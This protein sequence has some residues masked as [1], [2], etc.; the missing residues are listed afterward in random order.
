MSGLTAYCLGGVSEWVAFLVL[1]FSGW[2]ISIF[3]FSLFALTLSCPPDQLSFFPLDFF[4][5]FPF[6]SILLQRTEY[7]F[8]QCAFS[9]NFDDFV[10]ANIKYGKLTWKLQ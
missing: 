9:E 8:V 5:Y 3:C 7:F 2:G 10:F 4:D 1:H 6:Y